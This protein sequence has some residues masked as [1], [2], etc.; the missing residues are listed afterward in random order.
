[1]GASVRVEVLVA[2]VGQRHAAYGECGLVAWGLT[3]RGGGA[4]GVDRE[5][6]VRGLQS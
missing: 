3:L 6:E 5:V 4:G 2:P 1:M